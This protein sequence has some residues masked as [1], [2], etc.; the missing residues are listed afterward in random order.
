MQSGK[1][2]GQALLQRAYTDVLLPDGRATRYGFG[3]EVTQIAGRS[4]IGHAGGTFGFA[5]F[6]ARLPEAGLYVAVLCNT[7]APP[8]DLRQLATQVVHLVLGEALNAAPAAVTLA[9]A[10]LEE[11]VGSYQ[12][13]PGATFDITSNGGALIGHL[14]RGQR[15]L[16]ALGDDEFAIAQSRMHFRVVRDQAH[17]V[18]KLFVT[19]DGAGPDLIWPRVNPSP[20][21]TGDPAKP[22]QAEPPKPTP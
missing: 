2:V 7:D 17:R 20:E 22:H 4:M 19:T 10:A 16:I 3:W 11:F 5:A 6:E 15:R 14:G 18:T 12:A 1:L 8:V 13:G 21:K 9:P